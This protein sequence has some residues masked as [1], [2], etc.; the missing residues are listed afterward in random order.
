[1][2]AIDISC[3]FTGAIRMLSM[4]PRPLVAADKIAIMAIGAAWPH[5]NACGPA[6]GRP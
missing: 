6:N 2:S 1:M 3:V 4:A 5:L